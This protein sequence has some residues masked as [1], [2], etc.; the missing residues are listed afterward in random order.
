MLENVKDFIQVEKINKYLYDSIQSVTVCS[1]SCLD[2]D[3]HEHNSPSGASY[4]KGKIRP[5]IYL[6]CK[7]RSRNQLHVFEWF[8][9]VE[10]TNAKRDEYLRQKKS[11]VE[12]AMMASMNAQIVEENMLKYIEYLE[13]KKNHI[14]VLNYKDGS[15]LD[16][17]KVCI[18]HD[19]K[20]IFFAN[21]ADRFV[22]FKDKPKD[23]SIGP[24]DTEFA[25][26]RVKHIKKDFNIV[27][28]EEDYQMGGFYL[29]A[30]RAYDQKY[31]LMHTAKT[32]FKIS[33]KRV[34][35]AD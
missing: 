28:I 14:V 18:S 7:R 34:V 3:I 12:V 15:D 35:E 33:F 17:M 1:N 5:K 22:V 9:D 21:Q 16:Q 32:Q 2:K 13:E 19:F 24:E 4:D 8:Q 6:V 26:K 11:I 25:Q 27:F 30:C 23:K 10:F 29:L 31:R 20:Q